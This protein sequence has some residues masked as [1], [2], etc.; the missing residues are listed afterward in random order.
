MHACMNADFKRALDRASL[1]AP[2]VMIHRYPAYGRLVITLPLPCHP[3]SESE[4]PLKIRALQPTA[5]S[6]RARALSPFHLSEDLY[7]AGYKSIFIGRQEKG[8]GGGKGG[9]PAITAFTDGRIEDID[10]NRS[11]SPHFPSL[12]SP[13]LSS[14]IHLYPYVRIRIMIRD[15]IFALPYSLRIWAVIFFQKNPFSPACSLSTEPVCSFL[16]GSR[17]VWCHYLD[18]PPPLLLSPP[19]LAVIMP[20]SE[21]NQAGKSFGVSNG[22]LGKTCN[23]CLLACATLVRLNKK[24]LDV[25][26]RRIVSY[27]I[28]SYRIASHPHYPCCL[29]YP[30]TVTRSPAG[31]EIPYGYSTH[32]WDFR[33]RGFFLVVAVFV[34]RYGEVHLLELGWTVSKSRKFISFG[35]RESV[36]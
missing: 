16:T 22:D 19:W 36:E 25:V 17:I 29:C 32:Y 6:F 1:S 8:G 27:R 3:A 14:N 24:T 33:I 20:P 35:S 9:P 2:Y 30:P 15:D 23:T 7:Y 4:T 26:V 10:P 18:N 13:S 28:V 34:I 11:P 5:S 21:A 12:F 31:D